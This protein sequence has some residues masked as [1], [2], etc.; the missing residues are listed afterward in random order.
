VS[1]FEARSGS[2]AVSTTLVV[3]SLF[4]A[5]V[6]RGFYAGLGRPAPEA[7]PLLSTLCTAMCIIAWFRHY[8]RMHHIAWVVDMGWFLLGAWVIIVPYYV[9]KCEG[10]RGLGRI[11]LF[12][13]TYFAAWASGTAVRIWV[14]VLTAG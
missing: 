4:Q 1:E 13:L 2:H 14:Q 3:A 6:I 9:L 8:S 11:G 5:Q 12:C 10:R 7:W